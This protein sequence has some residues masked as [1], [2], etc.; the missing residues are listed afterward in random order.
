MVV[1]G[2][3]ISAL[4]SHGNG[5]STTPSGNSG[6]TGTTA[7]P[8]ATHPAT[9][10]KVG[11]YF[12][13]Q[14][15]SGDT[16]RVTLVK[17][18]DPAQS[19]NEFLSPDSGDRFLGAVFKI[20]ALNGSP[21]DEDANNDAAI[22]GSNGQNY[23]ANFADIVGYTNFDHGSVHVAQGDTVT[24]SVTFQVPDGVKVTEVQWSAAS[25]FSSTVQWDV[26]G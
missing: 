14:D 9:V 25:G 16:Y 7:S 19:A 1:A 17:I 4:S 22:V 23:S 20:K 21:Q 5:V 3:A 6:T 13:I 24:G 11:S 10:A 15:G 8:G 2:I 18:I 12:D 26:R